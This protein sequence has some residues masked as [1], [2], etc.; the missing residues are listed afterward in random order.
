[1]FERNDDYYGKLP[2]IKTVTCKI[3]EDNNA[4]FTALNAGALDMAFH[5]TVDQTK[6]LTNGYKVTELSEQCEGTI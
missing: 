2:Q 4:L 6:N 1:M 5:L 3:F